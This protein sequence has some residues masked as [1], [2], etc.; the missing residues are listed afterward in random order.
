MLDKKRFFLCLA[1]MVSFLLAGAATG[2]LIPI[3]EKGFG[4]IEASSLVTTMQSVRGRHTFQVIFVNNT[5]VFLMLTLGI[6]TGGLLSM[7]EAFVIGYMVGLLI[8]IGSLQGMPPSV[9]AASLLPHGIPEMAA[10]MTVGA[11]GLYFALRLYSLTKGAKIDW[12]KEGTLY[13]KY[14]G[15]MYAVLAFAAVIEAYISPTIVAYFM[16]R[17][18]L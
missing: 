6:L 9:M 13:A 1:V 11:I 10:F 2:Y 15:V 18:G 3:P 8:K 12:E 16:R 17:S 4:H 14:A 5:R 7:G